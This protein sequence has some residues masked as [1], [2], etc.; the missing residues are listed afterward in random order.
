MV[1]LNFFI[2]QSVTLPVYSWH[3]KS[4]RGDP[5]NWQTQYSA[6][7]LNGAPVQDHFLGPRQLIGPLGSVPTLAL[8]AIPEIDEYH[9]KQMMEV[10]G[11]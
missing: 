11:N 4:L 1:K 2:P 10:R 5:S 3:S 7:W 6:M 8:L 9:S